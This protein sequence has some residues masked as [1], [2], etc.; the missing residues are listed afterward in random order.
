MKEKE[1]KGE[2]KERGTKEGRERGG[3]ERMPGEIL[4]KA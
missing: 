3:T 2:E 4:Y 1:R